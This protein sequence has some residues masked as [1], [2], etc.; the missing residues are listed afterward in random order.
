LVCGTFN[1]GGEL[2]RRHQACA[3]D[4]VNAVEPKPTS[5]PEPS[6]AMPPAV[7]P[8]QPVEQTPSWEADVDEWRWIFQGREEGWLKEY[9]GKHIAVVNQKVVASHENLRKLNEILRDDLHL[10]PDRVVTALID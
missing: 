10:D 9:V 5:P 3:N 1:G 7:P 8:G 2:A 4:R 6:L